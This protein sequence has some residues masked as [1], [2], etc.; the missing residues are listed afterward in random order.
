MA[1]KI[2]ATSR[3]LT[4]YIGVQN[5]KSSKKVPTGDNPAN[6][7]TL[8]RKTTQLEKYNLPLTK[9]VVEGKMLFVKQE[10]LIYLFV[11]GVDFVVVPNLVMITNHLLTLI[12]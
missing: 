10:R 3:R 12:M 5:Y 9:W 6:R 1:T 7:A 4:I 11:K 8:P 2:L